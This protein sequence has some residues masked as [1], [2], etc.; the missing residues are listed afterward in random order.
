MTTGRG[1]GELDVVLT[2]AFDTLAD[3]AVRDFMRPPD[4]LALHLAGS[5]DVRRVLVADPPRSVLGL[6][7]RGSGVQPVLPGAESGRYT[8]SPR[9]LGRREP[10][11]ATAAQRWAR[12]Y[13]RQLEAA[14]GRA[15]LSRPLLLTCHPFVAAWAPA[16]WASD[17]V[18]YARDDWASHP[19]YAR[20]SVAV[21]AAYERL[22]RSRRKVA[23][24]SGVLLDQV[25][26]PEVHGRGLV[27]PNGVDPELWQ[28]PG[29]S[30]GWAT[31][32][33]R[34]LAVYA[35][36]VDSRLD[37]DAILALSRSGSGVHVALVGP[38]MEPSA[39]A[40]LVGVP[41]VD[42]LGNRPHGEVAALLAAADVALLLH[43][44]TPLTRSMDPLKLYEYL[45]AGLPVV[46]SD[47]PELRGR[48]ERVRLV[49]PGAD[50]SEAVRAAA[51]EPRLP[52]LLRLAAVRE[53]S[54]DDR[55]RRLLA[56]AALPA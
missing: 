14:A 4:R 26:G 35:G 13:D 46:A 28:D 39:V 11:T 32:L 54:W 50:P 33:P 21:R 41:G 48:G 20:L 42:L 23:A 9:R 15:G 3:A 8:F 25:L 49:P 5:A 27:V 43:R 44:E 17:I 18:Y 19:S 24:V 1:G 22:R 45:A 31:L 53:M 34:P 16:R 40:D 56:F 12:W 10:A 30:P 47:L 2:Y 55:F 37:T 51:A 52:E 29:P 36:S 38:V 6:V 7:R